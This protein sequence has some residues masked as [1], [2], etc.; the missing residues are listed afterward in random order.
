MNRGKRRMDDDLEIP[1]LTKEQ[2]NRFRSPTPEER[3]AFSE[4]V[5]NFK[6]KGRPAKVFGKYK[7]ITIRLHPYVLEWAK[8]EAKRRGIGY[9]TLINQTL[10][11]HA[12]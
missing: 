3:K 8:V 12:A 10:L 1:P 5:A 9:Q 4:A 2:L 11:G 6:K 7:P